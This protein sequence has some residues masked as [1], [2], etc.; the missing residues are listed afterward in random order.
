MV[1]PAIGIETSVRI[2]R[3]W[4]V[5][6]LEGYT[7][8]PDPPAG[9]VFYKLAS[10]GRPAGADSIAASHITDLRRT[11][12]T[13]I[14]QQ[15]L[16][17]ITADAYGQDYTLDRNGEPG[18]KVSL[19]E[20]VNA[21]LRNQLPGTRI[22]QLSQNI[23]QDTRQF[24]MADSRGAIWTFYRAVGPGTWD[25]R[26][27]RYDPALRRWAGEVQ[28]TNDSSWKFSSMELVEGSGSVWLFFSRANAT[29]KYEL[30]VRRYDQQT[31][32]WG[33]ET[34]LTPDVGAI[35]PAAVVDSTG[36]VWVFWETTGKIWYKRY[37]RSASVWG[38]NT[39]L[40]TGSVTDRTVRVVVD[41]HGD[42][43]VFWARQAGS[44]LY[45]DIYCRRYSRASS[46]WGAE[47]RLSFDARNDFLQVPV[48]DQAGDVWVFWNSDRAG[49]SDND[50]YYRRFSRTGNSWG[51]ETQ[52]TVASGD[53]SVTS[54]LMGNDGDLWA[55]WNLRSA[56][57]T[58]S[59]WC[60]R[61]TT[62]GGWGRPL[63]IATEPNN[64][65]RPLGVLNPEGDIWVIW[66][67]YN[68]NGSIWARKLIPSI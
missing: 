21:L 18:L 8:L 12:L 23:S 10:L 28:L 6:V 9:H 11:G 54:V 33:A 32:A 34:V 7:T 58:S 27:N 68:N 16:L 59:I 67:S 22:E 30:T 24:T 65:Y 47:E 48:V 25:I 64:S 57:S 50:V 1:N 19:R 4:V 36:D 61:Y 20:A 31:D 46:A 53:S 5:R 44:D 60:S 43:W 49:M 26:Y 40:S 37:S 42:L 41:R 39:Q 14:P 62:E 2:R 35:D 45:S 66:Y 15:D 17:Q 38:A 51:S 3:E 63:Q 52:L 55:F 13:L 29:G 56:S